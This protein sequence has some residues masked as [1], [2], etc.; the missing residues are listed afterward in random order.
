MKIASATARAR[1]ATS[2]SSRPA[3]PCAGTSSKAPNCCA[4]TRT[5]TPLMKPASTGCG[6]DLM[7]RSMPV[8]LNSICQT[9]A[10]MPQSD[11]AS[12]IMPLC[13]AKA[14]FC[15]SQA[16]R[17]AWMMEMLARGEEMTKEGVAKMAAK[18]AEKAPPVSP[19]LAPWARL[20]RPS[21]A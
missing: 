1:L 11:M 2:A 4:M 19:A 17:L 18:I 13:P 5:A 21:G 7:M 9:P 14:W 16:A 10:N 15:S 6:V 8:T 3:D 12:T 20:C